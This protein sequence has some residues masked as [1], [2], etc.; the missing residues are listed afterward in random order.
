MDALILAFVLAVPG[1]LYS[2]RWLELFPLIEFRQQINF[3]LPFSWFWDQITLDGPNIWATAFY[4]N[5][6]LGRVCGTNIACLNSA[7]LAVNL[8]SASL[9]YLLVRRFTIS[10]LAAAL[11][12][13]LWLVS[14]PVLDTMAWQATNLDKLSALFV[15]LGLNVGISFYRR[16]ASINRALIANAVL[17]VIVVLA[18]NAKPAAWVLVPLLVLMPIIGG[19]QRWLPWLGNLIAPAL[20]AGFQSA[21][22]LRLVAADEF[23]SAHV[24]SG[25]IPYNLRTYVGYLTG[26]LDATLAGLA[27]AVVGTGALAVVLWRRAPCARAALWLFLGGIGSLV[28][29]ARTGSPSVFYMTVAA[30]LAVGFVALLSVAVWEAT[31]R[32]WMPV[33]AGSALAVLAIY[34]VTVAHTQTAYDVVRTQSANFR[35]AL[36][37]I[38]R[39]APREGSSGL[40]LVVPDANLIAYRFAPGE[41]E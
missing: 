27:A 9:L 6:T 34:G 17:F 40:L 1:A 21:H 4:F 24:G 39:E 13:T 36:P 32:T 31:P 33:V 11:A 5:S 35:A 8:L 10:R 22:V 7:L 2:W 16:S 20:Y 37:T 28:I 18:H 29:P 12:A 23:Y 30:A 41:V 14:L 3:G 19:G 26:T 25:D 38:A 15:L